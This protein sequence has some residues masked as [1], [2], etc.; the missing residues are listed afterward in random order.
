LN[1]PPH[2]LIG[3]ILLLLAAFLPVAVW[4][5]GKRSAGAGG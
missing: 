4:G 1:G 2:G 5:W 3:A